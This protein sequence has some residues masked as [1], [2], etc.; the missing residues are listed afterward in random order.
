MN[1]TIPKQYLP[2]LGKPVLAYTLDV[3][4]ACSEI[5]EIIVVIHP[6]HEDL[7]LRQV[8]KRYHYEKVRKYV[9]G[10]KRRQD[11]VYRGLLE[12]RGREEDFVLVHDGVRPLLDQRTLKRCI[13]ELKEHEAVCCAIPCVDTLK[14][15][16]NG[17]SIQGTLDRHKVWRAQ[18]P[19]GFRVKLLWEALERAFQDDFCGT[20]DSVLVERLGQPVYLVLGSEDNLKITTPQDVIFAEERLRWRGRP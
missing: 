4:E 6:H 17:K 5:E 12:L 9:F 3:F 10:G 8:F 16:E 18:T 20:D 7:F 11:S 15:T 2:L 14:M 1:S 13:E 19:Q